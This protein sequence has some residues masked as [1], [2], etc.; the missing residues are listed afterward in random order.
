MRQALLV[1]AAWAA[2]GAAWCADYAGPLF[3]AQLGG[4]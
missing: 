3:D 1:L 4:G 2:A